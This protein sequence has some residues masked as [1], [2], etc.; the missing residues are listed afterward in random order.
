MTVS[1]R[2]LRG[3][4]QGVLLAGVRAAASLLG[5]ALLTQ[6]LLALT[7]GDAVDTLP[8]PALR[9]QLAAEWGL[10]GTVPE[11]LAHNLG[12]LVHLD[13]GESLTWRPGASVATLLTQ[14]GPAS[15]GR[16]LPAA[17]LAV[18]L[19][20]VLARRGALARLS[21]PPA[22]LAAWALVSGLNAA[23]WYGVE[24]GAWGRPGWFTLPDTDSWLRTALAIT[25][26][27]V[28]SGSLVEAREGL[29]AEVRALDAAPFVE[30][31]HARGEAV[32]PVYARHL[33]VPTCRALA[34]RVPALL[35]S[36]VI[37]ER[38]LGLPGAGSALW[39]ACRLRDWPIASALVLG[40]A[41]AVV[42]ARLTADV[43][44]VAI[45]PRRRP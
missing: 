27:G 1:A 11:R 10:D 4:A 43:V 23:A 14:L 2:R 32:R 40:F 24:H 39:E 12:R 22:F 28:F 45:D 6:W 5:A 17:A 20:L 19:A 9:A 35:G 37:V 26:L 36:L 3:V 25:V 29:A 33:V 7:P 44:A 30:A 13:L 41:A 31:A 16:L 8:D 18:G 38:M 21:A 42:A 34:D 15:L